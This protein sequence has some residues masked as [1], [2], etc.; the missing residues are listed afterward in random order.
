VRDRDDATTELSQR[1]G[2]FPTRRAGAVTRRSTI[3][4]SAN[5]RLKAVRRL[6]RTRHASSFVVEGHRQLRRALDARATVRAVY[7]AP[8]LFL[9]DSDPGLVARAERRGAEIVEL[10]A[11][12]FRSISTGVRPDGVLAVVE[13]WPTAIGSLP[14]GPRP[15]LLVAQ[16]IERP[17]NLG[18][19][20]RTACSAGADALVACDARADLF[21]PDTVRGAVG[22]LFHVPLAQCTTD[23]ALPWLRRR[24]LRIVVAA[25]DG[26]RALWDAHLDG[27]VA[28]VV[29]SERH[30]VSPQWRNAAHETVS[31][32]MPGPSDSLNVAVAA[33]VVLFEA[34]RRRAVSERQPP[35]HAL[36]GTAP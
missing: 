5:D 27:P 2:R 34:V 33:G 15:L 7:A 4:S 3:T 21:H 13:R 22:T 28:V 1:P 26:E 31:I 24:G 36:H 19:I 9:G 18:T 29:G 8:E 11:R 32:P 20:V 30:G 6:A 12:A 25:P 17:G 14:L 23:E 10:G 35:L 16:G